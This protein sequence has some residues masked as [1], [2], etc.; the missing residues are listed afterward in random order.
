MPLHTKLGTSD[1]DADTEGTLPV[2]EERSAVAD[3]FQSIGGV[4]EGD[5]VTANSR[6]HNSVNSG[7]CAFL[8][9]KQPEKYD[10]R[11]SSGSSCRQL[12]FIAFAY[13][14]LQP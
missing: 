3:E 8:T 10:D 2:G 9:R 5:S 6:H 1:E 13:L 4:Y 12:V 14:C 11:L 7:D